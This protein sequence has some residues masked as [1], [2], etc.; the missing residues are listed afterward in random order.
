MLKACKPW[1]RLKTAYAD[2]GCLAMSDTRKERVRRYRFRFVDIQLT[3]IFEILMC[4]APA[5]KDMNY[6][7][8]LYGG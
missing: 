5:G 8:E 4:A 3:V 2:C 1:Y 6:G 7:D